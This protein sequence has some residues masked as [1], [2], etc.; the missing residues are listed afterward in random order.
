MRF[1]VEIYDFDTVSH[2]DS[3]L[4]FSEWNPLKH[5]RLNGRRHAATE[6]YRLNPARIIFYLY[7]SLTLGDSPHRIGR[8]PSVFPF[9][10]PTI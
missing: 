6:N 8:D 10:R 5:V 2:L 3:L 4:E 1:F 9:V 7:T